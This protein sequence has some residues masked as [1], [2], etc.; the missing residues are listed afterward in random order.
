MG[1][2][3]PVIGRRMLT[4]SAYADDRHLRSRMAIFR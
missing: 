1:D 2:D 4:R 3:D